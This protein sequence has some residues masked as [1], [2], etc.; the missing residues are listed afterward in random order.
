[1]ANDLTKAAARER[2]LETCQRRRIWNNPETESSVTISQSMH[3]IK[4]KESWIF[5][6]YFSSTFLNWPLRY[7]LRACDWASQVAL[8]IKNSP[9][10]A[11]DWDGFDPC[12]RKI[13]WRRAWQPTPVFLPG[14]S[15]W[16]EEP[17]RL[18][19]VGSL[20]VRQDWSDLART[21]D[22]ALCDL[23]DAAFC[24]RKTNCTQPASQL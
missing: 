14:E 20:R 9:V 24:S 12:V 2:H 16:A 7:C 17:G 19:S 6:S 13:P 8:V 23:M 10:N 3:K 1:M 11:G 22:R 5:L 15:P 21:H 4:S 18:Q